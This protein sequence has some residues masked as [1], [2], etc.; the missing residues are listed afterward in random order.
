R[1][2]GGLALIAMNL[3]PTSRWLLGNPKSDFSI[4][5]VSGLMIVVGASWV[6]MYNTDL[7]LGA[8]ASSLGR[9]R[10]L[11]P[12]LR[13][14]IAYPLRSRFPTGVTLAMFT[15]VVFTLVVGAI[16]TTSFVSAFNDLKSYG[17][18][19]DVRASVAPAAPI[20]DIYAALGHAPGIDAADFTVVSSQSS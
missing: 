11:A 6:L 9:V 15:R 17:G 16:P 3:L 10:R 20:R 14:S 2:G 12:V 8:L 4:F 18:G 19:F 13:M 7:L 1:T 5:I